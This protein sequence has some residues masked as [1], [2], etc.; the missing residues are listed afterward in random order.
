MG[1]N[2]WILRLGKMQLAETN[3]FFGKSL[4]GILKIFL[5]CLIK[6][7]GCNI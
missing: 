4:Y 3:M 7:N 2:H 6:C 5:N 1:P